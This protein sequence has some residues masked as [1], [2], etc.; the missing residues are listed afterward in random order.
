MPIT[1]AYA[2][3]SSHARP[4]HFP[5]GSRPLPARDAE[6]IELQDAYRRSGGLARGESLAQ[7][8]SLVG[9]GG[10]VDLAR[11]IVSGQLFSFPW[12]DDFWLP[13]FQ[14]DPVRLVPHEAPRRVL[15]E[16]RGALDGWAIAHWYVTPHAALD[17]R[18]PVDL[19]DTD[20]PAVLVAARCARIDAQR[21][22]W[23][24]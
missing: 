24:A 12:H 16:L 17:E 14:F 3:A 5:R 2:D 15:A 11:R 9:P 23:P 10:Y 13:M 20:L 7:R 6:F 18:L 4:G 8:M 19:L 21:G 22:A 1:H